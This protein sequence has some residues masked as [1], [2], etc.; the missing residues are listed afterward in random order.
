MSSLSIFS[1]APAT[2]QAVTMS[3]REIAGLTGKD[4]SHVHRD[5]RAMLTS[6]NSDVGY[7]VTEHK[8]SRG[9][10]KKYELDLSLADLLISRYNGLARVPMRL[11]EE[12]ALK[13]IEQLLC[14]TLIRQYKV[15]NYRVDGY[16]PDNNVA[17]EIDETQHNS[18]SHK[19]KDMNRQQA[20]EAVL[21]CKFV[22]I[23][24]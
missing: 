4:V 9:Y 18:K 7:K 5:I 10:T 20:I 22:R 2:G 13:T 23:K 15:L 24:L 11:Q 17:Y 12:S 3:S 16:D 19:V 21:G 1:T 8:D 6:L 14:V